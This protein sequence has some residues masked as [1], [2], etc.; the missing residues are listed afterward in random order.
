MLDRIVSEILGGSAEGG[1]RFGV[2]L[3][4]GVSLCLSDTMII[5]PKK[6]ACSMKSR[7]LGGRFNG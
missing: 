2:V 1:C 4:E 5:E 7:S 3:S 6:M